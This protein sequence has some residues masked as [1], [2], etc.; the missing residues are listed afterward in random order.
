MRIEIA[1]SNSATYSLPNFGS[2]LSALASISDNT[3]SSFRSIKRFVNNMS[4]GA[5]VLRGALDLLD[6]R[7]AFEEQKKRDLINTQDKVADFV[8]IAKKVD[9]A[10]SERVATSQNEFYNVHPWAKPSVLSTAFDSWYSGAQDWLKSALKRT[11]D[12]IYHVWNVYNETDY[13]ALSDEELQKVCD[14]YIRLIKSESL[15]TDDKIRV[16]SLL[17]YLSS[18]INKGDTPL[19]LNNRKKLYVKLYEK[20][21]PDEA[22]SIN[23]FFENSSKDGIS[24]RDVANIKFT[25]YKSDGS[26]HKIFFDNISKCRVNSWNHS[27]TA[28]YRSIDS[29]EGEWGVY[30]DIAG[31]DGLGDKDGSYTT[32]FHEIGHNIDDLMF[33]YDG[34]YDATGKKVSGVTLTSIIQGN[35]DVNFYTALYSDTESYFTRAVDAVNGKLGYVKLNDESK[36]QV[37]EALLDGRKKWTTLN[38]Y[39]RAIYNAIKD[40][41]ELHAFKNLAVSD[42]IGGVTNNTVAGQS[43]SFTS[44]ISTGASGH[45]RSYWYSGNSATAQ[46][47]KEFFAEYMSYHMTGQEDKISDMRRVFPTACKMMD[48][49]WK[50]GGITY[51]GESEDEKYYKWSD[52]ITE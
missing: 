43:L 39:E 8:E 14:N 23:T 10:V 28:F 37:V 47:G 18:T 52:T 41:L 22:K 17:N 35:S 34:E 29:S 26:A 38:P 20:L 42:L 50:T 24:E 49:A 7:L 12:A 48:K 30:L 19:R 21:H 45:E 11:T 9:S 16:Q 15:T 13:R 27:G 36:R 3:I 2:K 31:S 6:V 33:E 51:S 25:A 4:G 40:S 44:I 32:F 5:G 1:C 46:Q